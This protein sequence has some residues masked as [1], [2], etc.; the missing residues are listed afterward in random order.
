MV[1]CCFGVEFGPLSDPLSRETF[2]ASNFDKARL[3]FGRES[4]QISV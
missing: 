4:I 2:T 3:E 1:Q